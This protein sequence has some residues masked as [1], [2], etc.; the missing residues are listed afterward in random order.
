MIVFVDSTTAPTGYC[1]ISQ[2]P[3]TLPLDTSDPAFIA[4]QNAN[5][6][7]QIGNVAARLAALEANM[8]SVLAVPVIATAVPT[9]VP[10]PVTQGIVVAGS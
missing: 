4:F 5:N 8:K 6:G 1:A 10:T 3:Y 9:P 7:P 2:A